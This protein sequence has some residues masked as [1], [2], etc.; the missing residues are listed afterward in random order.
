VKIGNQINNL[1]K[2]L[3]QII[4]TKTKELKK[5]DK[6]SEEEKEWI[7]IAINGLGLND[8]TPFQATERILEYL[9]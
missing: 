7:D 8:V 9:L 5:I 4:E 2:E 6:K 1:K 3:I